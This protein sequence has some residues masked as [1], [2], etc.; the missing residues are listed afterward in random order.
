MVALFDVFDRN[1]VFTASDLSLGTKGHTHHQARWGLEKSSNRSQKR[2]SLDEYVFNYRAVC[3][4]DTF[5]C[6]GA[7]RAWLAPFSIGG[8]ILAANF[9]TRMR[10]FRRSTQCRLIEMYKRFM[11][12]TMAK[13]KSQFWKSSINSSEY[14]SSWLG[15][16]F[17]GNVPDTCWQQVLHYC[18]CRLLYEFLGNAFLVLVFF[19]IGMHPR[20]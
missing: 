9:P 2:R 11:L 19:L 17:I 1:P 12:A 4:F 16:Y 18:A 14:K 10:R 6:E 20:L 13:R 5:L 7:T 3:V 8:R 15:T